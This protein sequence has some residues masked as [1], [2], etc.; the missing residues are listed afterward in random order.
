MILPKFQRITE[1]SKNAFER[2]SN[3]V[4]Y[5]IQDFVDVLDISILQL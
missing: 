4:I 1:L 3:L 2:K 5:C